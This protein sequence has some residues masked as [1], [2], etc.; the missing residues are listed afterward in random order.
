[1]PFLSPAAAAIVT[2]QG[3]VDA[4]KQTPADVA[5]LVPSVVAE[6][7]QDPELLEY[8][9][10]HLEMI[11]YIGG[12]LPQSIG[13]TVA[14][15]VRLRC[16]WGASEVGI[17]HQLLSSE[18]GPFDWRYVRFHP[19]V[20]ATF[21]EV[22]EG[23]YELVVRRDEAL[24]K[25]QAAFGIQG[26]ERLDGGYR[27]RDLF[28]KHSTIPDTWRWRARADDIIV[29]LNGEKT[30]PTLMEQHILS[31]NPELAGV[32]VIG[33]QRFQAALL[34]E[35]VSSIP[36]DTAGQ[37]ALIERIWPS[38]EEANK[39]TPA[40]ARV[41]KSLILVT[42][43][44]R[45]LIRAG[46][47]TVQKAAN[48]R[49][50]SDDID[51]LY[52]NADANADDESDTEAVVKTVDSASISALIQ[53]SIRNIANLSIDDTTSFFDEG[54]DSLQALQ[55][56]RAL[57]RNLARADIALPTIYQ[58]PTVS[59]LTAAVLK[60]HDEVDDR[61]LI[62]PLLTSYRG[63][64]H[65]IAKPETF[66]PTGEGPIDVILTGSTGSLGTYFLR[67]LL[68]RKG[69]G[70]V[71]CLNRGKDG[72]RAA[73]FDRFKTASLATDDLEERVTFLRADL[74][75]PLLGLDNATYETLRTRTGLV[76]HNAW[77]VNFNLGL[78]AFRPHLAGV[79]NM[80]ALAAAATPRQMRVLFISSVSAA[81]NGASH[82]GV[83]AAETIYNSLDAPF[84]NGYARSKFVSELLCDTA[85][86]HVGIPVTIARVGQ[87]AGPVRQ[88]GVWNRAEWLPTIVISSLLH[89]RCLPDNLG[90]NE[91]DWIPS[92]LLADVV[93]D[94][95]VLPARPQVRQDAGTSAEVF[96]LCNPKAVQ[97]REL[98]STIQEAAKEH[99]NADVEVVS[100]SHWLS[101]LQESVDV[102]SKGEEK[103]MADLAVTNPAIKL[104]QYFRDGLW[105]TGA[106]SLAMSVDRA[107]IASPSLRDLPPVC[108]QWIR[109]WVGEWMSPVV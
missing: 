50:Y 74:S 79:V 67:A 56:S 2:A 33:A 64:I 83:P 29:F 86:R 21:E 96:N 8:C 89:L 100:P 59:Q 70:H 10:S 94:L 95:A 20:G 5:I 6:L 68:D 23:L 28:E 16:Q 13:D 78:A 62:E 48:L 101:R 63:L 17:P 54:M 25:T 87:V 4:L 60:Q 84:A 12:D 57:R 97:W 3:L 31:K 107:V 71:F 55:L 93:V 9:A 41:E 76:I 45:P 65:E 7:A 15:K 85:A 18:L 38:V 61:D 47:G 14:R 81:A 1:M 36:L 82:S 109:K 19:C 44:D 104:L 51:K 72:G 40:H 43:S 30:N 37:A 80:F 98:L 42:T 73:Q 91:V 103:E 108:P 75:H 90:P 35:P 11:L 77:P 99:L 102:V 26:Q 92:D 27:T 39:V 46:K 58:N 105:A 69:V 49:E 34:I 32:I 88:P 52:E 22:G 66:S 106:P 53:D 24:A